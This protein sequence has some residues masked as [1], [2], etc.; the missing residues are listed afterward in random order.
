MTHMPS[1]HYFKH[2]SVNSEVYCLKRCF[3]R[4]N[5]RYAEHGLTSSFGSLFPALTM[6]SVE[7]LFLR[8]I[9]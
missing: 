5:A 8:R 3:A 6:I 2:H 9:G 7:D 1:T 4:L